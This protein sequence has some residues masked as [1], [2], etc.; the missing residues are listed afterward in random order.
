VKLADRIKGLE[1]SLSTAKC[2]F[3][4]CQSL[5]NW[6]QEVEGFLKAEDI[7]YGDIEALAAQLEQ[8]NVS[9][10]FFVFIFFY[11]YLFPSDFYIFLNVKTD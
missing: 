9:F 4:D 8:C 3:D 6:V 11:F 10:V 7:A 1:E 2:I 5:M